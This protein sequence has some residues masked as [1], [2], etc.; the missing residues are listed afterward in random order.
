M[1][2]WLLVDGGAIEMPGTYLPATAEVSAYEAAERSDA[3]CV[4]A[5][6]L[7]H[8]LR[9]FSSSL[10]FSRSS[11]LTLFLSF[12]FVLFFVLFLF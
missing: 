2:V 9:C 7:L 4:V 3:F 12:F 5:N 10:F 11:S 1:D 8:T 6:S